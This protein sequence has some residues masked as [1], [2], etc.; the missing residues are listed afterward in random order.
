MSVKDKSEIGGDEL[1]P[2]MKQA[3]VEQSMLENARYGLIA[4]LDWK[5][6]GE[7][8]ARKL[9][10]VRFAV[11]NYHQ[12][13][14]RVLSLEEYDGYMDVVINQCPNWSERV[15]ELRDEHDEFR[16]RWDDLM[17]K[18]DRMMPTDADGLA[19][20]A[21]TIRKAMDDFEKHNSKETSL[22]Q[23]A[24]NTDVGIGD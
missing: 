20:L 17:T 7:T 9:S 10:T 11:R 1:R 8:F 6:K 2:I 23:E 22:I 19:E 21:A 16:R 13:L 4:S 12:H 15:T 24:L 3:Q 14:E 18:L 5:T